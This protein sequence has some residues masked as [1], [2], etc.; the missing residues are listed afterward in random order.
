MEVLTGLSFPL[1][2]E[3]QTVPRAELYAIKFLVCNCYYGIDIGSDSMTNVDTYNDGSYNH[4]SDSDL[5]SLKT[6]LASLYGVPVSLI[7]MIYTPG[8]RRTVSTIVFQVIKCMFLLMLP[9][10]DSVLIA[11]SNL[12]V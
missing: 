5:L 8:S 6:N 11:D 12:V 4:V 9:L 3:I 7:F 10:T 1:P 2:G